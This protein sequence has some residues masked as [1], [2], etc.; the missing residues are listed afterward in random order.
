MELQTQIALRSSKNPIDYESKVLLLGSCFS[1]SIGEKLLNFQFDVLSNPFGVIFNPVSLHRLIRR[2]IDS[3]EFVESDFFCDREQWQ[4]YELHST[5]NRESQEEAI[6]EANKALTSFRSY[7]EEATHLILTLGTAQGYLLKVRKQMVSNCHKQEA[8]LFEKQLLSISK[9]EEALK[10]IHTL[11]RAVNP[12]I[13]FVYTLSPV[14]H[15]KDGFV[16]N[17]RSKAHL[18]AAIHKVI[19]QD[20][21]ID[22]FPS[23]ELLLDEL[24]DY[25]FYDRDLL[26]PNALAVDYIWD[27]FTKVSMTD[28]TL[29]SLKK[30]SQI[31]KGFSHRPFQ[32]N[33]ESHRLFLETL[34]EKIGELQKE[35]PSKIWT[36]KK[37]Q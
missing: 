12:T 30:V 37:E 21:S 28:K 4:C 9:I 18:C 32:P 34:E 23:Y 22:Y 1:D 15:R 17:Q 11:V 3:E 29:E 5:F 19:D 6:K 24:R 25:R 31:S 36:F 20:T 27:L 14:R 10:Q 26:H 35:Y 16:E 7:L 13:G 8:K 2:A 33:T